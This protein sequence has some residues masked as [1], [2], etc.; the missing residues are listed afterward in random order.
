[1]MERGAVLARGKGKNMEVD[2]VRALVAI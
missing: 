2:G 1:V